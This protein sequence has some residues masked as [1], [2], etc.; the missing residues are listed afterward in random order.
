MDWTWPPPLSPPTR[1]GR[2]CTPRSNCCTHGPLERVKSCGNCRWLFLDQS[3]NHSR[4]W[5][6]M[7]E[8]HP[9]ERT[10][11]RRE[12]AAAP[13]ERWVERRP[14]AGQLT[15]QIRFPARRGCGRSPSERPRRSRRTRACASRHSRCSSRRGRT[16]RPCGTAK[17]ATRHMTSASDA[18]RAVR[19]V[20]DPCGRLGLDLHGSL[21]R[22]LV[23]EGGG[24]GPGDRLAGWAAAAGATTARPTAR[25]VSAVRMVASSRSAT[26]ASK[27]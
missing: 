26:H 15:G 14:A 16:T 23:G 7:D 4:R 24:L 11:A 8:R 12:R 5:C 20:L 21:L 17:Q 2:S 25:L 9:D 10:R 3:R 6:R 19:E 1:C 18:R 22:D 13:P 27:L